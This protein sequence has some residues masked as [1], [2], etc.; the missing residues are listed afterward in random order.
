MS[1]R[2]CT[3]MS[4]CMCERVCSHE[5]CVVREGTHIHVCVHVCMRERCTTVSMR[6]FGMMA[7]RR[8]WLEAKRKEME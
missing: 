7:Q 2:E 8:G 3:W 4:V 6:V 5:C 1:M